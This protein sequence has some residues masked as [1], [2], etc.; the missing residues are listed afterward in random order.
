MGPCVMRRSVEPWNVAGGASGRRSPVSIVGFTGCRLAI[1]QRAPLTA[2]KTADADTQS[3]TRAGTSARLQSRPIRPTIF[4]PTVTAE[5][6]GHRHSACSFVGVT[7]RCN[8]RALLILLV[9][10]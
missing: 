1:T 5:R 2:S 3:R 8:S 4:P 9:H 6:P 7:T 10:P